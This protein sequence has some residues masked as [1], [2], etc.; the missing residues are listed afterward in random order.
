MLRCTTPID[1]RSARSRGDPENRANKMHCGS[2]PPLSCARNRDLRVI[3]AKDQRSLDLA[4][5]GS[6]APWRS[7]LP[8][9]LPSRARNE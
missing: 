6:S 1:R 3:T 2:G 7:R 4:P 5:A 9:R 8:R